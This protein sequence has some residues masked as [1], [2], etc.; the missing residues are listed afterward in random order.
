[1]PELPEVETVRRGLEDTVVGR[2]IDR[3]RVTGRRSVRRQSPAELSSRLEGRRLDAARR[4]GKFL[5]LG[6]DDGEVL[7]IHLRMSGQLIFVPVPDA[8]GQ[9]PHTHVVLAFE[10]KSELRFVD[11]RTFGEWYVTDDVG[12]NGLP[13]DFSR[14]GPDPLTDR[15]GA[16][17]LATR[18]TRRHCTLKAALTD[19]RVIA[20]I[21]NLYADEIC[22]AARLRPDRRVDTLEDSDKGRL[23]RSISRVLRAATNKRG[24]SLRDQRYRDLMGNL[25]GYQ[26]HHEVYD[27]AG[28][29]CRRCGASIE[30][31]RFGARVAYCCPSCQ[32]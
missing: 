5:A 17:V 30:K 19:Q 8:V 27:R 3:V 13:S 21:G 9:A 12:V 23:S 7:V 11:P 14:F 29:A 28:K 20:G 16:R 26:A 2:R 10:D 22:W 25:G 31:V 6:L 15:L 32:L 1:M 4:Y 24:S 18:L